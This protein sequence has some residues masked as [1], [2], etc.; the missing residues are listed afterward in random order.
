MREYGIVL[1]DHPGV[2]PVRR[3]S[4]D[5]LVTEQDAPTIELAKSGHH[6]QQ[7]RLAAARWSKQREEFGIADRDGDIVDRA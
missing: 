1:E 7:R 5:P 4:I 6:A 3:Q 2:A